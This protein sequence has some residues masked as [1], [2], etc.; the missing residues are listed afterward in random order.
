MLFL[1]EKIDE[2]IGA[3]SQGMKQKLSIICALIGNPSLIILDESLSGLDPLSSYNLKN[4][5]QDITGRKESSVLLSSHLV[6]S[7]EK[8]CSTIIM[9]HKGTICRIWSREQ[10]AGEKE[11]THKDLEQIFVDTISSLRFLLTLML[12]FCATSNALSQQ[13]DSLSWLGGC[14]ALNANGRVISE[15]WMKPS[16]GTM[17]GMSR[18][19]KNG[20]TV[21]FEFVRLVEED[22]GSISYVA[23]PSGQEGA[24]F[25]LVSLEGQRA[26]FENLQHDFPQRITYQLRG[27]DSLIARIEGTV[28]GKQ[29]GIDFPMRRV[30]CEE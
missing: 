3:Y 20:K 18:T 13:L 6:D 7:V 1:E 14:W 29:K 25:T 22:D 19:V 30:R 24:S 11:R 28:G 4:Y 23:K 2:H 16:G 8:Y 17:M 12:F 27:A 9:L 26:V 5:L 10:L 21:E 15:Q